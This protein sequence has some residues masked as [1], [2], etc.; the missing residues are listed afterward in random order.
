MSPN[1]PTDINRFRAALQ[2]IS[3]FEQ[4][5]AAQKWTYRGFHIWPIAK[6]V[7]VK[8]MIFAMNSVDGTSK[9]LASYPRH[10]EKMRAKTGLSA[11]FAKPTDPST[12]ISAL[13][14]DLMGR[15]DYWCFGSGS[16]FVELNGSM[17]NQHH[18]A[19]R[20]ALFEAG[21][22]SLGLYSGFD[23]A[24]LPRQA[25][26]GPDISLDPFIPTIP[27]AALVPS[28]TRAH[29]KKHM[30]NVDTVVAATGH[31]D[32][33]VFSIIDTFVGRVHYMVSCFSQ[34]MKT[35]RPKAVFMINY[36]SV[37]GW[38][39]AHVCRQQAVDFVDIQHGLQGRFNGSYFFEKTPQSDWSILPKLHL[40]WSR[41]DAEL[42]SGQ[43]PDRTTA[44]VGP[45][46]FQIADFMQP[47]IESAKKRL[48]SYRE[49]GKPLVLF[50]GQ[51]PQD[52][53]VAKRLREAGLNVLFR[54]H[55]LR[56]GE[57]EDLVDAAV[58]DDLGC[59]FAAD[60]PLPALLD[61]VDG[62]VTGHSAVLLEA[63][64]KNVPSLATGEFASLLHDDYKNETEG[65]LT[66]RIAQQV[67]DKVAVV[68]EWAQSI[69][70]ERRSRVVE[71]ASYLEALRD[72]QIRL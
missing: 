13:P 64:I 39:L 67:E 17:A 70:S 21:H 33:E 55:P 35:A 18:H 28:L 40:C 10:A 22:S 66:V 43:H 61:G 12:S 42:Y 46:W 36:A 16:G 7:F 59:A 19:L 53:L 4:T 44:V 20:V 57:A 49:R 71:R 47:A 9:R 31:A 37:Y 32:I 27:K 68:L 30:K 54:G 56:R 15:H 34:I 24:S 5:P 52:I 50:A 62:I 72:L 14:V 48:A 2:I 51:F 1:F 63:C 6:Y 45:T 3:E 58:V 29:F 11:L 41:S 38:A 23:P 8:Q 65:L 26:Y 60:A 25:A 69:G